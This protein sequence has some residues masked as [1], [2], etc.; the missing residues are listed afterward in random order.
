[1]VRRFSY[2]LKLIFRGRARLP[3]YCGAIYAPSVR[4]EDTVRI[5]KNAIEFSFERSARLKPE[6][7]LSNRTR[8]D[9]IRRAMLFV[10]A[11]AQSVP[12]LKA[13]EFFD[14]ADHHDLEP[15]K[16]MR[17]WYHGAS[18]HSDAHPPVTPEVAKRIFANGQADKAVSRA[19]SYICASRRLAGRAS[20]YDRF[21]CLWSGF[22]AIYAYLGEEE[23]LQRERECINNAR[24]YLTSNCDAK[25]LLETYIAAR[26][27]EILSQINYYSFLRNHL[28]NRYNKLD[29]HWTDSLDH[30]DSA[31]LA[32][33]QGIAFKILDEYGGDKGQL[34]AIVAKAN[35]SKMQQALFLAFDYAYF[36][37]NSFFHGES[38]YPLFATEH[39]QVLE[40]VSD[41]VELVCMMFINKLACNR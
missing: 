7:V 37:R 1:M 10:N 2:T 38:G 21:R 33:S 3:Q 24:L 12:E 5:T 8:A 14:G 30:M 15:P 34:E 41:L 28:V 27:S 6:D 29:S 13:I 31:L 17:T 22:N 35:E 25:Q 36:L 26:P 16:A 23:G 40:L 4:T 32:K 9:Q 18:G 19:L 20:Q 39:D 11:C